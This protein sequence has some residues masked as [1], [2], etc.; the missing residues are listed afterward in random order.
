[1]PAIDSAAATDSTTYPLSPPVALTPPPAPSSLDRE[2]LSRANPIRGE[3]HPHALRRAGLAGQGYLALHTQTPLDVATRRNLF[4]YTENLGGSGAFTFNNGAAA[5]SDSITVD[6]IKL[7]RVSLSQFTSML[8]ST[9]TGLTAGS[10]YCLSYYACLRDSIEERF[11]WMGSLG[12]ASVD[13]FGAKL[14]TNRPRRI[15]QNTVAT[16]STNVDVGRDPTVALG[17]GQG[18][19]LTWLQRAQDS[20]DGSGV[21]QLYVGGFQLE[22]IYSAIDGIALIGDSTMQGSAGNNDDM[23]A[24]EVSRYVEGMLNAPVYNRAI[25]GQKLTDMDARWATSI[26]PLK[27]RCKYVIIQGGINDF[28]QGNSLTSAQNAITSMVSKAATDGLIPVLLTCTPAYSMASVPAYEANRQAL[29]AWLKATYPNVIDIAAVMEDPYQPSYLRRDVDWYDTVNGV[30]YLEK[31]KRAVA[32][33]I[34]AWPGW[35]LPTPGPYQPISA[36]TFDANSSAIFLTDQSTGQRYRLT[37]NNGSLSI[38]ANS[39]V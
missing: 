5:Q 12:S 20:S 33:T 24:R 32:A 35:D 21:S 36:S 26:T 31:A 25:G 3:L 22:P 11:V 9:I 18:S 39:G 23:K 29:N 27:A 2:P 16:N 17:S 15:W 30:H 28:S 10:A 34:A 19:D 37:V 38:T 4:R 13:G 7:T 6:S 8:T 14:L 1:M